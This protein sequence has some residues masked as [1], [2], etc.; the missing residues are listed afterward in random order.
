MAQQK[1]AVHEGVKYICR[2]CD[3]QATTEGCLTPHK[4]TVH[5]GVKCSCNNQA[6]HNGDLTENKRAAHEGVTYSCRQC[7]YQATPKGS[8]AKHKMGVHD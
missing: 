2:Q 5:F 6:T 1:R 4:I 8:F 7:D 3:Y